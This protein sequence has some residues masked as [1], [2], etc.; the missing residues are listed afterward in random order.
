VNAVQASEQYAVKV[1]QAGSDE[2]VIEMQRSKS[3][4]IK[5]SY[6]LG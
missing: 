5:I 4:S 3:A 6:I 1:D 2:P